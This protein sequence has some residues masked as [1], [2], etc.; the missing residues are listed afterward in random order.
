MANKLK[1]L[2][3]ASSMPAEEANSH[4]SVVVVENSNT[5]MRVFL[6]GM[7]LEGACVIRVNRDATYPSVVIAIGQN[8]FVLGGRDNLQVT[9]DGRRYTVHSSDAGEAFA[10]T[11]RE[12]EF[13]IAKN[14]IS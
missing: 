12:V 10:G 2:I 11:I 1:V 9:L 13:N 5:D 14:C 6:D 4:N 8:K 7:Y 3:S